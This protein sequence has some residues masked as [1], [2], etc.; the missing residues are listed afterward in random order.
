M[1]DVAVVLEALPCSVGA[2]EV[3]QCHPHLAID[4]SASDATPATPPT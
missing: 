4:G 2:A 1:V 3:Q